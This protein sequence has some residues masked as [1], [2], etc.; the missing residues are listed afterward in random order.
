MQ[1]FLRIPRVADAFDFMVNAH[2]GQMYG[3]LP[4]FT[5]P[6]QV[7]EGLLD[8]TE[9]ELIAALLHDVPEDTVYT[10]TDVAER[11]GDN[12]HSIVE[13]VTKDVNLS[14]MGNIQRVLASRNR[15]AMKVKWADNRANMSSDKSAMPTDR[16]ERLNQKYSESFPLLTAALG[17]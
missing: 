5:H 16:R 6:L 7:A 8:P 13:L 11:Y 9:D 1:L 10:L 4:Y 2:R 12:V 15:S 14:Y 17:Y 3:N